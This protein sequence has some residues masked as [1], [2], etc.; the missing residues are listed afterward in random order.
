MTTE[1]RTRR[2]LIWSETTG[3]LVPMTDAE[4]AEA[5]WVRLPNCTYA[6]EV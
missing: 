2:P 3:A 5:G 4:L 6:R 1:T